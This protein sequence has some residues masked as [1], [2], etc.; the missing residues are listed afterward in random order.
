M[1]RADHRQGEW[2][3]TSFESTHADHIIGSLTTF[4]RMIFKGHLTGLFPE[5]AFQRFLNT[6]G[7]LLKGYAGYVKGVSDELKV[8][9]KAMAAEAGRPYLYSPHAMTKRSGH[10]KGTWPR[11]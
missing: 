11:R 6:Q 10:S 3:M 9:A 8:H 4:D 2:A 1:N 7:V 5:G